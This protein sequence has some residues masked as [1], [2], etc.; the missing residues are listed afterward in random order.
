LLAEMQRLQE[1]LNQQQGM[2][3]AAQSEAARAAESIESSLA[4]LDRQVADSAA[5]DAERAAEQ[6]ERTS[7]HLAALHS[8]DFGERLDHARQLAEGLARRQAEVERQMGG[9][10]G[11][12]RI[13][14]SS[15]GSDSES[16]SSPGEPGESPGGDSPATSQEDSADAQGGSPGDEQ[17]N[18]T[19]SGQSTVG[20]P[21]GDAGGET[22]PP[23]GDGGEGGELAPAQRE[24]IARRQS[25]LAG[26]TDMLAEVLDGIRGDT[27][28]ED[29]G[30]SAAL[31]ALGQTT[32]ADQIADQMRTAASELAAGDVGEARLDAAAARQDLEE[33]AAGLARVRGQYA[34]P[35]MEEL[36]RLE[37]DLARFMEQ[38]RRE[39][40]AADGAALEGTWQDLQA[41]LDALA[42]SDPRLASALAELRDAA[43]A[44]DQAAG[45][46][47]EGEA[48]SQLPPGLYRLTLGKHAGLRRVSQAVQARIQEA[49]LAG[50]LLDADEPVPPEYRE[51]VDEYYRALSDD[52][53]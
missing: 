1:Q 27:L 9:P 4:E 32:P 53:Q 30:V 45:S 22:G 21:P 41:E 28:G 23:E 44:T 7:D 52:L 15:P 8:A 42:R 6:L 14:G 26:Q 39:T 49:I 5:G 34:Q 33:L 29:P 10:R 2:S 3:P 37:E 46:P 31:E 17:P 35:E 24:A 19:G 16:A 36:V 50:A 13:P 38:L 40:A 51:L 18:D 11:Q 47:G 12:G 43:P 20:D 25:D 48:G